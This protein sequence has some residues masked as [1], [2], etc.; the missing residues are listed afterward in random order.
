MLMKK[1]IYTKTISCLLATVFAASSASCSSNRKEYNTVKE[2]DPWYECTSISI[3]DLYPVDKYRFV[4]YEPIGVSDGKIYILTQAEDYFDYTAD[5]T[6]DAF[7]EHYKQTLLEFTFDGEL[8]NQTDY[9]PHYVEGRFKTIQKAWISGGNVNILE[10]EYDTANKAINYYLN[11]EQLLLPDYGSGVANAVYL[12]DFYTNGE[13]TLFNISDTDMQRFYI[14]TPDGNYSY[15]YPDEYIGESIQYTD[16]IMPYEGNKVLIPCYLTSGYILALLDLETGVIEEYSGIY[17]YDAMYLDYVSGKSIARDLDGFKIVDGKDEEQTA[18]LEYWQ[19]D[20]N[21]MSIVESELLYV[22]DDYNDII[23]AYEDYDAYSSY[24]QECSFTITHLNKA[25]S[26]PNAGKTILTVSSAE[27]AMIDY[28]DFEAIRC[29]NKEN[30]SCIARYVFPFDMEGNP[31]DV[32]ADILI[33]SEMTAD[34]TDKADFIDLAPCLDLNSEAFKEEYFT[35]AFDAATVDGGIYRVP[36]SITASG[37]VTSSANMPAGQVGFTFDSYTEFVDKTCNGNDPINSYVYYNKGKAEYFT[38]LFLNMTDI[39][40]HDG[41]IDLNCDEFRELITYVDEHGCDSTDSDDIFNSGNAVIDNIVYDI[42]AHNASTGEPEELYEAS[43]GM[44]YSID[45]YIEKYEKFGDNLGIY[46][47]PSFDGRGPMTVPTKFISVSSSTEYR[48]ACIEFVK[49]ELSEDIQSRMSFN[50]VNRKALRE[51]AEEALD[52]YNTMLAN[53]VFD[54]RPSTRTIPDEAVDRYM[55]ILNS[56]YGGISV[57]SAIEA[58]LK[59]ESSSFFSGAKALD[60][61]IPV[62][63]KRIQTVLDENG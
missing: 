55:D 63:Q 22:S 36:L 14:G 1:S 30:D 62:M 13:Y 35:N 9:T 2:S 56:S 45:D 61:V 52:N 47:L 23:L 26:N 24:G 29:F 46:G 3:D 20:A 31:K 37:I 10:E 28:S 40:I 41:K 51:L 4:N 53:G 44:F 19:T 57:G 54:Y 6:D 17:G 42:N 58:I 18:F 49:L 5:M 32:D 27:E 48:E 39:F 7:V 43:Y 15:I 11:G 60:D 50:P 59:E 8:T 34:P 16:E 38:D 33:T 12:N 21:M 25:Q